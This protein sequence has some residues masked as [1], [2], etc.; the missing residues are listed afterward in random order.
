MFKII[1]TKLGTDITSTTINNNT[2]VI[3][4]N[5]V[6]YIDGVCKIMSDASTPKDIIKDIIEKFL[7]VFYLKVNLNYLFQHLIY[8]HILKNTYKHFPF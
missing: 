6:P 3:K 8:F 1:K 2:A 5:L 7:N 4:S